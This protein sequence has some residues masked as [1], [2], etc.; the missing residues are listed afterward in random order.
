[1]SGLIRSSNIDAVIRPFAKTASAGLEAEGVS[2]DQDLIERE[3]ENQKLHDQLRALRDEIEAAERTAWEKGYQA[4]I[5]AAQESEN[6]RL[7]AIRDAL[8]IAAEAWRERL[9]SLDRLAAMMTQTA[10]AKMFGDTDRWLDFALASISHQATKL[11]QKAIL[12]LSISAEDFPDKT[13]VGRAVTPQAEGF[14]VVHDGDLRAGE[15]RFDLRLGH[16]DAGFGPQWTA[17][18]QILE[19]L[20]GA[21]AII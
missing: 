13:V 11:E 9:S 8:A 15:A 21:E 20:A 18:S 7:E 19:D 1:M 12:R 17:L 2:P 3:R 4:G 16:L 10:L 6:K 14:E 5:A